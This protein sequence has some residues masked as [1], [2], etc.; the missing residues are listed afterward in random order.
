MLDLSRLVQA[1]LQRLLASPNTHP[2]DRRLAGQGLLPL[3]DDFSVRH[4][5]R[6]DGAIF[7]LDTL[8][9]EAGLQEVTDLAQRLVIYRVLVEDDPDFEL[10]IPP[11]P[12]GMADCRECSGSG[13]QPVTT[14]GGRKRSIICLGCRGS[15]WVSESEAAV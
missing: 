13:R 10:L 9:P 3:F 2:A 14:I 7:T 1:K 11:R 6:N 5:L 12:S 4:C 15:G 8:E